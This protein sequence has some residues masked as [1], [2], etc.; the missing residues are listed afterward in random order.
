MNP[1]IQVTQ[2][3]TPKTQED[4]FIEIQTATGTAFQRWVVRTLTLT[5]L[6]NYKANSS[7]DYVLQYVIL[8]KAI[9]VCR[10]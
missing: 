8:M 7:I 6:V 10:S 9:F 5:K 2:I 4:E 3:K 1:F